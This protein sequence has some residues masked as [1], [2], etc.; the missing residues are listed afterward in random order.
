[1]LVVITHS[2]YFLKPESGKVI[3]RFSWKDGG[4]SEADC[5][6][7][8]VVC[9]LRGRWPPDGNS[10]LVGLNAD[11]IRYTQNSTAYVA[12]I[13]FAHATKLIYISHLQGIDVRRQANGVLLCK[14]KRETVSSGISPVDVRGNRIYVL[15]GDG[16]I[17]AL[18][19]PAV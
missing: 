2:I 10:R 15:T 9:M 6:Q 19:H 5:T 4:L 18:R 14:I 1:M 16:Y 7:R 11:G 8:N 17:Y 3:R 12:L 13:H